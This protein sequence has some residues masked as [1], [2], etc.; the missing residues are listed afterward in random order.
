MSEQTQRAS[1]LM[2]A[3]K[4]RSLLHL[5]DDTDLE[6][7]ADPHVRAQ[8]DGSSPGWLFRAISPSEKRQIV[9]DYCGS[10]SV[11]FIAKK[12]T[13]TRAS[14][15]RILKEVSIYKADAETLAN[16]LSER[17]ADSWY[18]EWVSRWRR[19]QVCA[20]IAKEEESLL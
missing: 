12:F 15:V 16:F 17:K 7:I 3:E 8:L 4:L 18:A 19:R 2:F 5:R 9:I 14:V 6:F 20:A 11:R 1:D 13:R 10:S